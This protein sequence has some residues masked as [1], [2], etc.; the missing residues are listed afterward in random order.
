ML[1]KRVIEKW[2]GS[3]VRAERN[4]TNP[5]LWIRAFNGAQLGWCQLNMTDLTDLIEELKE[6]KEALG[7]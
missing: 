3:Y 1:N 4:G 6:A 7:S 2:E 5:T